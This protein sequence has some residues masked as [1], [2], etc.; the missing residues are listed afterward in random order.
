M[1]NHW[2]FDD[3]TIYTKIHYNNKW[4]KDKKNMKIRVS[5]SILRTIFK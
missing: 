3:V 2:Y 5:I 1:E 4:K